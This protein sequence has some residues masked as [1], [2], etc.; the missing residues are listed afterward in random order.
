[1]Y[2]YY[3]FDSYFV[4][5]YDYKLVMQIKYIYGKSKTT[6]E[7]YLLYNKLDLSVIM[8]KKR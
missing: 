8:T 6:S 7:P 3:R 5:S 4:Q 1:M 2:T